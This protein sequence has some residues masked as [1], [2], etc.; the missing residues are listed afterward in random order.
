DEP[1]ADAPAADE[2]AADALAGD[3]APETELQRERRWRGMIQD[4]LEIFVEQVDADRDD[5][6]FADL[7]IAL[8][9]A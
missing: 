7:F 2:P 8:D 1:A 6:D 4:V 3:I 9:V 5:H